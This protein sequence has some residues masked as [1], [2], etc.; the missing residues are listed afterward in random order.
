MYHYRTDEVHIKGEIVRIIVVNQLKQLLLVKSSDRAGSWELPG[1][2]VEYGETALEAAVRE[3]SEETGLDVLVTT[4]RYVGALTKVVSYNNRTVWKHHLL[5]VAVTDP[6]IM[7]DND[8][9]INFKW[10]TPYE[11]PGQQ[12]A[13]T[14][15]YFLSRITRPRNRQ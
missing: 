3:L 5:T 4:M 2:K 12:L 13:Y 6:I 7:I 11:I 14:S 15:H 10:I 9:I 1:G 8:E